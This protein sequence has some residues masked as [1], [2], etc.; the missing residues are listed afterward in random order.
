MQIIQWTSLTPDQQ[1][2]CLARPAAQA[3]VAAG[4]TV[5]RIFADVRANGDAAVRRLRRELDDVTDERLCLRVPDLP[6]D[7]AGLSAADRDA[8]AV[9]GANIK[10][11][12]NATRDPAGA[13]SPEIETAPGVTCWQ[14]MRPID[15]VGLYVPGGS[16]PLLST[17][18]MLAIPAKIAGVGKIVMATPPRGVDLIDPAMAYAARDCGIEEIYPVGGAVA[19]AAMT[20]GTETIPRVDKIFGPGNIYVDAAKR[21]AAN[22]PGGPAIDLPGGPSEVLVLADDSATAEFVAADLLAQ[23]EHDAMA[24]VMLATTSARL[25]DEVAAELRRQLVGLPRRK[26]AQASLENGRIIILPDMK[27]GVE[28]ANRYAPEHL[29][30]ALDNPRGMVAE[31]SNAGSIFLG[32]WSPETAGDFASGTNHVLPTGGGARAH[33]GLS[34]ASFMKSVTVQEL[35]EKGLLGLAPT[36]ERLAEL[37]GLDAHRNAV[38]VRTARLRQE[39]FAA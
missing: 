30:L 31:I 15:T 6:D 32:H 13:T 28:L 7:Q 33:G 39:G 24:Q 14:V 36:L 4:E 22:L 17:L 21:F 3:A 12:H 19:I 9:A 5:A 1:D 27:S 11:F 23:A 10:R 29:I 18:L 2:T 34:V 37:E 26:I 35:T 16:A 38:A 8:I 25:A 20:W